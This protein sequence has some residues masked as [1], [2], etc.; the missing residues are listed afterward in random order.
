MR[1]H[2]AGR[3]P[4]GEDDMKLAVWKSH[5]GGTIAPNPRVSTEFVVH[6]VKHQKK[7]GSLFTIGVWEKQQLRAICHVAPL[8]SALTAV[9]CEME[10][11]V[12]LAS[13]LGPV[14]RFIL[15]HLKALMVKGIEFG[16]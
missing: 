10:H 1:A 6:F 8:D 14:R 12:T 9:R 4:S 5:P 15:A 13:W 7:N 3:V 16:S 11:A 2:L